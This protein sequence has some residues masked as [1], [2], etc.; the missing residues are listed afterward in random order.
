MPDAN[1][2]HAPKDFVLRNF[3]TVV[4]GSTIQ[5]LSGSMGLKSVFHAK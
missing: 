3:Q 1:H 4:A 2:M 5:T